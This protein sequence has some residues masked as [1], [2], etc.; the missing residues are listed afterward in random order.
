[1]AAMFYFGICFNRCKQFI[2]AS[3]VG[4]DF[5][6]VLI[7]F[8]NLHLDRKDGSKQAFHNIHPFLKKQSRS[9]PCCVD[10]ES[11]TKVSI[12]TPIDL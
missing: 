7:P 3:H 8:L 12:Q 4:N 11:D 2:K 1:M 9:T 5:L 10:T 6:S